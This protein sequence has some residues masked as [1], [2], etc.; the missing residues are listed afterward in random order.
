MIRTIVIALLFQTLLSCRSA[1]RSVE[2]INESRSASVIDSIRAD[3][4]EVLHY[5]SFRDFDITVDSPRVIILYQDTLPGRLSLSTTV[6]EAKAIRMV[7][8]AE[9]AVADTV[10]GRLSVSSEVDVDVSSESRSAAASSRFPI[11]LSILFVISFIIV[12]VALL[13]LSS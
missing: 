4:G 13:K 10:T 1:S 7:S 2:C 9:T 12:G 6:L 8:T 11:P 3:I 5:R